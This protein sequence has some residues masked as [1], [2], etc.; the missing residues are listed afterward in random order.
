[1]CCVT[2]VPIKIGSGSG[3][4]KFVI[5]GTIT[6]HDMAIGRGFLVKHKSSIDHE[7]DS[8]FCIATL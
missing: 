7:D 1:V 8:M 6:K 5:S 2:N 4:H 3:E